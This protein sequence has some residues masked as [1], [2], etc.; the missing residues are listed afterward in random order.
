MNFFL[1]WST[2]V[3]VALYDVVSVPFVNYWCEYIYCNFSNLITYLFN[4]TI[5]WL[6]IN[7]TIFI[8]VLSQPVAVAYNASV[9]CRLRR[10]SF[11]MLKQIGFLSHYGIIALHRYGPSQH[12]LINNHSTSQLHSSSILFLN[13]MITHCVRTG[14]IQNYSNTG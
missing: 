2:F 4:N 14:F 13:R 8:Y 10:H 5:H 1:P 6:E 3:V 11:R 7:T 12:K 9:T